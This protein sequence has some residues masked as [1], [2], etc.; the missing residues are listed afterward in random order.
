MATIK[1]LSHM[2]PLSYGRLIDAGV[3]TIEQ[4]LEAGATA[5]GRLS[6]ADHTHVDDDDV[7]RWVHQADLLRIKGM[8]PEIAEL[9]YLA[10]VTTAP[11]LAYRST[12][13]L[14]AEIAE[15]NALHA[16]VRELPTRRE[17]H[18]FI[19]E[20]KTLPKLIRH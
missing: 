14:Y 20:A 7:M 9:L 18:G 19:T 11:R 10:N 3:R 1:Q 17:L 16:L 12:D 2:T 15:L 5:A 4:L 13:S 6:L 8:T